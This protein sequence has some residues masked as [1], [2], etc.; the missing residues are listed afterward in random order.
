M[1]HMTFPPGPIQGQTILVTGTTGF[2]GVAILMNL[3][4]RSQDIRVIAIVRAK[5]SSEALHRVKTTCT[6]YDTWSD[7]WE[8]RLKCIPG[9]LA[10][11]QLGLSPDVFYMLE[12]TVDV[13]IHNGAVVHWLVLL[14]SYYGVQKLR[15]PSG[16]A[17]IAL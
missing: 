3:L 8:G 2:L 6:A 14:L 4:N 17:P 5:S 7:D 9:D 16:F 15:P 11:E 13:V 10:K 12:T 1:S